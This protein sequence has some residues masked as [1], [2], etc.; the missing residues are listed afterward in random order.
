MPAF[1][2]TLC[3]AP[4]FLLLQVALA[5]EPSIPDPLFQSDEVLTVR[6][7]APFATLTS[8]RPDQEELPAKFY[9]TEADGRVVDVDIEIRTRGRF[10]RRDDIC[11]FP[12][13]RLDFKKSDVENT[14]FHKQDK[15]KLVTHCEASS[16]YEQTVFREYL[17][18]RM[19]NVLTDLS[20]RVRLMQITYVD[21]DGKL[22]DITQHGFVIE[23]KDRFEKR[24]ATVALDVSKT[25]VRSLEPEYTNLV[26]IYQFMIGN[27][28]FSPIRAAPGESCCHNFD[29]YGGDGEPVLAVPYDF[30]QSGLVD[31]PHS[32]PNPKFRISS[33]RKR[34][35]RG[36]CA[37]NEHLPKT[38]AHFTEHR[39]Q[40]MALPGSLPQV[41]KSSQKT[42]TR[43]LDRF[44][45]IISSD[46]GIKKNFIRKCI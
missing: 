37:N 24:I 35:Y 45:S 34:I 27:T 6:I 42:M 40:I 26:S 15:L 12:P 25:S 44:Y 4:L 5:A 20:Y 16:R 11:R 41:S 10:R 7:D 29:L 31:A 1:R 32:V 46:S 28:D 19:L 2:W 17:A 14:L 22:A 8:E 13:L 39:D 33:V 43:Y 21:T 38:I 23:Q 18:Y 9:F 3:S 36:R 30:D